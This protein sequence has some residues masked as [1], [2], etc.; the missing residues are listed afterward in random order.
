MIIKDVELW[1]IFLGKIL[2]IHL[3]KVINIEM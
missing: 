3:S 2:K 1:I